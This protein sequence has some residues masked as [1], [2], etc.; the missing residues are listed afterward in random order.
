MSYDLK[1]PPVSQ[2]ISFKTKDCLTKSKGN[3][4]G[5]TNESSKPWAHMLHCQDEGDHEASNASHPC[6]QSQ[7]SV[8]QMSPSASAK[9]SDNGKSFNPIWRYQSDSF[10]PKKPDKETVVTAIRSEFIRP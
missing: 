2:Q 9:S 8:A 1:H 4:N 7:Q 6:Q 5:N 10:Y 3:L